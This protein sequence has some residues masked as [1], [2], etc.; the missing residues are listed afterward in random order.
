[1]KRITFLLLLTL[2]GAASTASQEFGMN[3]VNYSSFDWE[4]IPTKNFDIYYTEGG[5][6]T[7]LIASRI[8]ESSFESLS[9][10]W[11]Y[12]PRKRIPILVFNS[13]NDFAQ[14]NVL[15]EIIEE[16]VGGFTEL[17]KNRVVI[18]WEGSLDKFKHV[19][20]HELTHALM[21]DML[22]GGVVESLVS[23][24]YTFQLP[25]WFAEGLAEHE[26]QYWST[27]ADMIV[28]D[29][30]ISGYLPPLQYIYGGYLVYKGG[31]SFFKF[32]QEQYGNENKWIAGELLHSLVRTKNVDRTFKAVLGKDIEDLSKEWHRKLRTE[33]W[34]EV[35]GREIPEDFAVKLTDHEEIQ[36]YL[37]ISPAYNPT[38]DK[39]AF[40]TDR[41]GYKEILLMRAA[42]GKILQ[43]LVKGEKAGD[44]EEMHWLRSSITW[45]PDGSMIAFS[46]KSGKRDAIHI[47]KIE[48]NGFSKEIMPEM[49]AV[50]SPAWSPDGTRILFCGI[51]NARLDLF[52]VDVKSNEIVQL[53][54]DYFNESDP[55][56]S[57]DGTKIA[58]SSDLHDAPYEL[59]LDAIRDSYDI[60]V[61]QSDGSNLRRV[62]ASPYHDRSPSWSPDGK[63]LVF[64]SDRNGVNNLHAANLEDST[65]V[66]LTN[67]LTGA[68]SPAWSPD[69][70]NIAFTCFKD[71]G[72][73][74]YVLKRPLKREIKPEE[75]TPT[76]Y[77]RETMKT[78]A[79]ADSTSEIVLRDTGAGQE[80][81]LER[82]LT[83]P[84]R[85]KFSPDMV[86]AFASYNTFYGVGGLGQVVFSDIMGDHRVGVGAQLVYSLEES[87]V[88]FTYLYLKRRTNLGLSLFHYKTYYY[89]SDWSIF[90]DRIYGG[91]LLASRPF[92][93]FK[94][95]DFSLNYLALDR[96]MYSMYYY[97]T[98]YNRP[99]TSH[100]EKLEGVR[101]L[102]VEANLVH[103]NA[104]W[105]NTGPAL[106]S[107]YRLNVEYSPTLSQSDL[108]YTTVELDYRKYSRLGRRYSFIS[109]FSG[110]AS[111][112]DDP[113]MFF[114]GG[115]QGWL[116]ARVAWLGPEIE[117]S[118]DV[119]FA[120][121]VYPLRGFRWNEFYG[122]HYFL[123]N[124]EFRFPFIDYLLIGW[125]LQFGLG[126][127]GGVMFT[128]IGAAW[129]K[130]EYLG[131][132][133]ENM[134]IIEYDD[135]FHGGGQLENGNFYLDD[136]KMSFG[137]GMRMNLGFAVLRLDTA[138]Q[139]DLN[140]TKPSPMFSISLGPDF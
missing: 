95:V 118:S 62:A 119:Y 40:L 72:W 2:V 61:M 78:V 58:F 132:D 121:S 29:G 88:N 89:A 11:G 21:F 6:E 33:H 130:N 36:N 116:N 35:A 100:G 111:F 117:R 15:M 82:S 102:T 106:G 98:Y 25:L 42:D 50:Y 56:W 52:T 122:R 37:N 99:F 85:I 105:Q 10:H 60:F 126:N 24:E 75:V 12:T 46:A 113:R 112:G 57:A 81:A 92:N 93:R 140:E 17:F 87:N 20:H 114:M 90:G 43:T 41:G 47:V 96:D 101:A 38:G 4:F 107:R 8:A 30:I 39:I 104:L 79:A 65:V 127:I 108:S 7:A 125:P 97:D 44:Y 91:S 18:P 31:E 55:V 137:V 77:R 1:M 45:S 3:K 27:E 49:D 16:G 67:L 133:S 115:D 70:N 135:T 23:R 128:D 5:Y 120:R 131:L 22:Y 51:R 73:D 74:V 54:D 28:R 84:Y 134:P 136:I 32:I 26:S 9:A 34:P 86:N 94:R 19:I 66:P 124:F 110:G 63:H 109:R 59:R 68:S 123:T 69:G 48:E 71:G 76:S 80:L 14:T 129:G 138:W 13:H 103:D 83:R 139:T 64:V 53:T